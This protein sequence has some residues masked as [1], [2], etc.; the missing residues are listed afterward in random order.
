[1]SK[2]VEN[3]IAAL[4]GED[5]QGAGYDLV[6]VHI[7]GG[8][9]YAALQVMAERRDEVGMTVEDCAAISKMIMSKIDGDKEL[10]DKY[11]LEVSSP[12]IDRP[13]VRLQDFIRF[14]GHIAK[15]DLEKPIE[16]QKRFQ[17]K[18]A[19]ASENG[20]RFDTE[21]G[22]VTAPVSSIDKAKLVLTDALL[23]AAVKG[24]G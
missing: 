23:K 1:M 5:L 7:S 20:I 4:I 2:L 19:D 24:K 13:L 3:N 21:K 8:G 12:G 15:V 14:K 18:I 22:S 9:K 17:G 16:G 6:R 11:D 10:A